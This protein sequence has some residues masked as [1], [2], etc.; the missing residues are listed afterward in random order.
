[1]CLPLSEAATV[2]ADSTFD[3]APLCAGV[4]GEIDYDSAVMGSGLGGTGCFLCMQS[5]LASLICI[6]DLAA[7]RS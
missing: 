4:L 6:M 5:C 2:G 3:T 1:M 7:L